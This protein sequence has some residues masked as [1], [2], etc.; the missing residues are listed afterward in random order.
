MDPGGKTYA[1]CDALHDRVVTVAG[2][3]LTLDIMSGTVEL[4]AKGARGGGQN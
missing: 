3:Q 2:E 4:A 1:F